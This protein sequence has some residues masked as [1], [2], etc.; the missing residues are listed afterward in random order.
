MSRLTFIMIVA[1]LS[2]CASAPKGV[3]CPGKVARLDGQPLGET[4]A[5]IFDLV[6][7]FSVSRDNVRVSSGPLY[8]ADHFQY[9]PAA[10]TTEGLYAQRLS[11]R[12]FRLINPW[13]DAMITWICPVS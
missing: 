8:S 7:S 10:V 13:S 12:E 9:V 1:L 11:N 2:G 5:T 3:E 4:H 6:N